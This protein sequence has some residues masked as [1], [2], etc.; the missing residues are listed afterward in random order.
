MPSSL[1]CAWSEMNLQSQRK[2]VNHFGMF[3]YIAPAPQAVS[4]IAVV[5]QVD[6]EPPEK[7]ALTDHL[8]SILFFII[9]RFGNFPLLC[10]LYF[11]YIARHTCVDVFPYSEFILIVRVFV[12]FLS[13][14]EPRHR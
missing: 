4:Y 9:V 12:F 5:L 10:F 3:T 13:P 11:F 1:V 7:G 8:V 14:S 6:Y 2:N